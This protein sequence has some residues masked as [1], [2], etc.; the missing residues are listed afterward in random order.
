MTAVRG[1]RPAAD[2][3][4]RPVHAAAPVRRRPP[5]AALLAVPAAVLSALACGLFALLALAFSD[6]QYDD[7]SWLVVTVPVLLALWLL[8]G[9]VLLLLGRSWLAVSLPAAG[10]AV[11]LGWVVLSEDLVADSDG[12]AVAIWAL[13]A[14]TA[15]A[16]VLPG[17]RRWVTARR[18]GRPADTGA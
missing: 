14:V 6:G 12:V 8:V 7:G 2:P 10:L 4:G 3:Y 18:T 11:F 16:A 13:P 15:L 1:L 17:V 5:V 9:A